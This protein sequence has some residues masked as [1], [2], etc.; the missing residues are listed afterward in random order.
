MFCWCTRYGDSTYCMYC[1]D[2]AHQRSRLALCIIKCLFKSYR[3]MF[4]TYTSF[5]F[6]ICLSHRNVSST[7]IPRNFVYRLRSM[8]LF[9]K[10][11]Y[12]KD[13]NPC[14]CFLKEMFLS[15]KSTASSVRILSY[16][17]ACAKNNPTPSAHIYTRTV[18]RTYHAYRQ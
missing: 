15:G 5:I 17:F 6:F 12:L 14:A 1:A 8:Y 10:M 2:G 9:P 3:I 4:D 7:T 11:W 18:N 16:R 13:S